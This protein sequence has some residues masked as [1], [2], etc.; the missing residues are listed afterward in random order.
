MIIQRDG[1]KIGVVSSGTMSPCLNT[2]I[3][4]GYCHPEYREKDSI[5]DIIIRGKPVK[6]K[7]VKPPFVSKDWINSQ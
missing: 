1:E 7:V 4:M 6:S 2:G 3:A 5:N